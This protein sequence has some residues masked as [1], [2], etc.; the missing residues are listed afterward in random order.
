MTDRATS[1]PAGGP[2]IAPAPTGLEVR[3]LGGLELVVDGQPVALRGRV[4]RRLVL[5]LLAGP[6]AV[7]AEDLVEGLWPDR[8]VDDTAVNAVH[9]HVSRLRRLLDPAG[10]GRG[11]RWLASE[12]S[13]Y[14]LAPT[15]VD[16]EDLERRISGA[17]ALVATDPAAARALLADALAETLPPVT[18]DLPAWEVLAGHW[19]M[20]WRHAE[21]TWADLVVRSP[22]SA[23]RAD[24][25]LALA[26]AEPTRE[27]RWAL[28]MRALALAGRQAEALAA[29][30]EAREVLLEEVGVE[31]GSDLRLTHEAVLRQAQLTRVGWEAAPGAAPVPP[32]TFVGREA[33]LALLDD[34]VARHRVVTV[35]GLGGM[36]KSRLVAEWVTRSGRGGSTHWVDLR[37]ATADLVAHRVALQLGLAPAD[38]SPRTSLEAVVV[39]TAPLPVLVVLDDADAVTDSVSAVVATLT[40]ALPQLTVLT[41]SRG[42]LGVTGERPV[43]LRALAPDDAE[44]LAAQRL[45]SPGPMAAEVGRR[46]GGVPLA[47]EVL[48]PGAA[49]AQ[50]G[51]AAADLREAVRDAVLGLSGDAAGVFAALGHLPA[52]ATPDLV[53]SLLATPDDHVLRRVLRELVGSSLA[54]TEPRLAHDGRPVLR[55]RVL[56]PVADAAVP[57]AAGGT[58]DADGAFSRWLLTHLPAVHGEVPDWRRVRVVGDEQTNLDAV[59]GRLATDDPRRLLE[60][61]V[62]LASWW[63]WSGQSATGQRWVRT[64][65]DAAGEGVLPA[66]LHAEALML[67]ATGR[68]LGH[69]ASHVAELDEAVRLLGAEDDPGLRAGVLG[70]RAVARGW[71]GDLDGFDADHAAARQLS[72]GAGRPW[73]DVHLDSAGALSRAA[74]GEPRQAVDDLLVVAGRFGDLGDDHARTVAVHFAITVAGIV[75]DERLDTLVDLGQEAAASAGSPAAGALIAGEAAKHSLRRAVGSGIDVVGLVERLERAAVDLE[76]VGN[77]R[78]AAVVRRDLGLHLLRTGDRSRAE[79]ELR[80]AAARLLVLDPGAGALAVAALSSLVRGRQRDLLGAAA[81]TLATAGGTPLLASDRDL[82]ATLTATGPPPA[83]HAAPAEVVS[84]TVEAVQAALEVPRLGIGA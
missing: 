68:G 25:L 29:Y 57:P 51:T 43:L 27:V 66:G 15:R 42:P 13:R 52:G 34:L 28:A 1:G 73:I 56:Q 80:T 79:S 47:V 53:R 38:D 32:T 36:G 41:T 44:R 74:R 76:R 49:E 59:L 84:R 54:V 33:E 18:E 7:T 81:W 83:S 5:A 22:E 26:R 17:E 9:A 46:S 23:A 19:R 58:A 67:A 60:A 35:H 45:G 10:S 72:R 16:A 39:S 40:T 6:G 75:G 11:A 2:S 31:P 70:L 14:R 4:R 78:T 62:R 55:H 30:R 3:V 65:L 20:R 63:A 61:V 12:G 37:G 50:D 48:A 21:E 69:L 71:R 77:G 8:E 82:L 24:D 64:G